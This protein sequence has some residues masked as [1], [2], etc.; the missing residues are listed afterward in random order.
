VAI[1]TLTLD[2][3]EQ[4]LRPGRMGVG[5]GIVIDS[6]A[7]EEFE[8]CALKARFLTGLDPGFLLFET[9]C[10]TPADGVRHLGRHMARLRGSAAALG[11]ACDAGEIRRAVLEQAAALAPHTVA[12]MRLALHRDGRFDIVV[13]PL[14][15]LPGAPDEPVELLID[16]R[17]LEGAALLL[18]HKTTLR[19]RYDAGMALA[20]RRGAFDVLHFNRDGELTEGARSNVFVRIDGQWRTP[21]VAAGLLPGVMRGVLLEDAELAAVEAPICAAE[22]ARAQEIIVCNALRG[23]L[24][25]RVAGRV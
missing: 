22:L 13:A 4:G 17:P 2:A 9:M 7:E 15:P 3:P 1:R 16:D 23:A 8:E 25:A 14:D 18:A 20:A 12:R 24:R 6:R 5:A 11:F 10:V 19:E 21:P